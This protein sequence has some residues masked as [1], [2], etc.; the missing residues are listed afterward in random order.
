MKTLT[1]PE[2]FEIMKALKD[3]VIEHEDRGNI[4]KAEQLEKILKGL[5]TDYYSREDREIY[6]GQ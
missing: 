3:Q 4:S 2:I 5:E 1:T 6:S